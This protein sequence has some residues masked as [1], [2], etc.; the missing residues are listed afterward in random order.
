MW[1]GRVNAIQLQHGPFAQALDYPVFGRDYTVT[2]DG[3]DRIRL[4]RASTDPDWLRAV[5][6]DRDVQSTVRLA[7][8]RR[9][10]KLAKPA[11]P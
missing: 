8:E 3:Q 9:L 11:T 2:C 10:R 6:R 1:G 4:V 5:L 7:A